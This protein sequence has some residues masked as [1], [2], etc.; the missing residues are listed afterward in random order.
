MENEA[1]TVNLKN[2]KI[3]DI[4]NNPFRKK[5]V[6]TIAISVKNYAINCKICKRTNQILFR[7]EQVT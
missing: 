5:L 1:H 7:Y 3:I 6:E 2:A 4:E